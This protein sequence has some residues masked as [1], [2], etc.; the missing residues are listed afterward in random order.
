MV[1]SLTSAQLVLR[2][3]PPD[4]WKLLT[5]AR[6]VSGSASAYSF[7]KK[8][9]SSASPEPEGGASSASV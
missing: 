1:L 6:R 2:A 4:S 5:I 9:F 3:V 8:A 7:W